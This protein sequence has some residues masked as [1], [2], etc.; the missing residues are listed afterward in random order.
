MPLR[1]KI[2]SGTLIFSVIF[3]VTASLSGGVLGHRFFPFSNYP[4]FAYKA[5]NLE[6]FTLIVTFNDG[7]REIIENKDILPVTRL[8]LAQAIYMTENK[9][10]SSYDWYQYF[11][12]RVHRK[13]DNIK[14]ISIQKIELSDD[15]KTKSTQPQYKTLTTMGRD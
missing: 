11:F 15:F 3:G 12:N 4:M 2:A 6:T 7:R 10:I 13:K 8:N 5:P 14:D 1:I 9:K